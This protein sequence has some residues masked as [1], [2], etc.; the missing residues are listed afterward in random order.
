MI[1]NGTSM[2]METKTLRIYADIPQSSVW[3]FNSPLEVYTAQ[4]IVHNIGYKYP[5]SD[6]ARLFAKIKR[7]HLETLGDALTFVDAFVNDNFI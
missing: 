3:E 6:I 2:N 1:I 5:L 7:A 4:W